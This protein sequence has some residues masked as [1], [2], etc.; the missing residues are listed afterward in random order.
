MH[1]S[2]IQQ[3]NPVWMQHLQACIDSCFS[4]AKLCE[5]SASACISMEN[6]GMAQCI[7][8][9]L[10]CADICLLDAR[11][12]SRDSR[13]HFETCVLCAGICEDCA[14]ACDTAASESNKSIMEECAKVCRA[15]AASCRA[16]ASMKEAHH[17]Q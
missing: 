8:L 11:F 13:Y 6:P 17:G 2:T 1:T 3:S 15:C 14:R 10:D 7:K 16:M 4:C 9:C 12:M 5:Q